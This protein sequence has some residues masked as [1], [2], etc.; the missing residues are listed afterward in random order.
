MSVEKTTKNNRG[1]VLPFLYFVIR[2]T[3]EKET[4]NTFKERVKNVTISC[5]EIY[6]K[7]FVEY[8]Y[9]I[10]SEAFEEE[11]YQVIKAE[12]SNFLHLIGV[13]T[14]MSPEAFL[15]NVSME[16]LKKMILILRKKTSQKIR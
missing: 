8:D 14:T 12:K 10:C 7:E 3:M 16:R 6:K 1:M 15:K 9:L 5:A 13:N 2:R 11:K 4:K